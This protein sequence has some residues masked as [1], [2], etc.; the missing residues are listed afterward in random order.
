MTEWAAVL[1]V[2]TSKSVPVEISFAPLP[3]ELCQQLDHILAV[4]F[5]C[6]AILIII[7]HVLRPWR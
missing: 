6:T 3:Q 1:P 7:Y 2:S 4:V 5:V